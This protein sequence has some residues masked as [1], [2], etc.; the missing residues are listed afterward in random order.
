MGEARKKLLEKIADE[1]Y[2]E[3][4]II[5]DFRVIERLKKVP[6]LN[7]LVLTIGEKRI[8]KTQGGQIISL[9]DALKVL[10]LCE[11]PALFPCICRRMSGEEGYY[12]LNF[13]ILPELYE[14]ANPDEYMEE[15]SV[16]KAKKLLIEWDKK[17]FYHLILWSK[18]PYVTTICN[19][20]TPYCVG[21]KARFVLGLKTAMIKGEYVARVNNS[22]CVGCKMC[23]TR[24]PF[25]AI[26]FNINE[27]RAFIDINKCFGCGLCV[28]GCK[29]NA[30]E[31]IDRRLTPAKNLW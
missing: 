14:K 17:G 8:K 30:I 23:L 6:L 12:C 1:K 16:S 5:E 20:T 7:K 28:T 27:E 2:F 29:N 26:R 24:C 31:L 22:R 18:A 25:G 11:N 13:G 15:L 4:W 3:G 19:C 10:E 9:N 21:Y